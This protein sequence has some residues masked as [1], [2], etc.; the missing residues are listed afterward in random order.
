MRLEH[1][2]DSVSSYRAVQLLLCPDIALSSLLRCTHP[3]GAP[4]L[5][6]GLGLG[7]GLGLSQVLPHHPPPEATLRRD[8]VGLCGDLGLHGLHVL[9]EV[10]HG[11]A[12]DRALA[13]VH[14]DGVVVGTPSILGPAV[15]LSEGLGEG[16]P[17]LVNLLGDVPLDRSHNLCVLLV[18][19]A[20]LANAE[21]RIHEGHVGLLEL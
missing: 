20:H 15:G 18:V 21:S 13:E 9:S 19:G 12:P 16:G 8:P 7:L 6:L 2:L 14:D 3:L 1:G 11:L 10:Q 17:V 4:L 5:S